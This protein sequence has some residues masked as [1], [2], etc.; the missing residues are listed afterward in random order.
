MSGIRWTQEDY[1][2]FIAKFGKASLPYCT[3][4][5]TPNLESNP[6]DGLTP[7]D[8]SEKAHPRFRIHYHS[9]RRRAIDSDGLYSKAATDGLVAGGILPDDSLTNVSSVQ[10]SQELSKTEETII[11]IWEIVK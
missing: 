1:E 10:F 6:S 9:R 7:E 4:V 11:E 5:P 3:P 8:A 2:R